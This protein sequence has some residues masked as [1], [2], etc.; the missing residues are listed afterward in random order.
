MTKK[1]RAKAKNRN[2]KPLYEY[3]KVSGAD[4]AKTWDFSG[5]M[6]IDIEEEIISV[7]DLPEDLVS[8]IRRV[9]IPFGDVYLALRQK[10]TRL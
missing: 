10:N 3:L 2:L 1:K 4:D 8:V 7:Y 9:K 5:L 6:G